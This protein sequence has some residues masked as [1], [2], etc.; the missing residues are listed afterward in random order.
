LRSCFWVYAPFGITHLLPAAKR[1]AR[2][3]DA[4]AAAQHFL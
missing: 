3:R 1:M 2:P 4:I